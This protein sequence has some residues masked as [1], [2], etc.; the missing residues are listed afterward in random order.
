MWSIA[1]ETRYQADGIWGRTKDG[2]H[3]WIVA[4]KATF[5]IATDGTLRLADE[6]QKPLVQAEYTGAPGCSSLRYDADLVAP[7]PTTDVVLNA[8]AHAP[9]GRPSTDFAV[10]LRIGSISKTLRVRGDRHWDQGAF[11]ETLSPPQ[12]VTRVPIVYERAFGGFDQTDP[13]PR[14]QRMDARNPIGCGV[15]A[16]PQRRVGQAAPNFEYPQG[17]LETAG[18]AG[19]GALDA[20]WSPRRELSGTYDAE[21]ERSRRPLLP[22]DWDPR[23]LLS[24]PPDQRPPVWFRGGEPVELV[25]LTP[26]GVMRFSLPQIALAFRTYID[27]RAEEHEGQ[28]TTVVIDPDARRLMMVW[29]TSLLC[30]TDVDYLEETLVSE[31]AS[32]T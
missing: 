8:T 9:G 4:V 11:G 2:V 23:S 32:T 19:V 13:D 31:G 26:D 30:P 15:V 5:E 20:H 6:Q 28:L 21:W 3:I 22:E 14:R 10:T 18:P 7:K 24:A 27:R 17:S 25:N 29:T 12:P 16:A 1:N